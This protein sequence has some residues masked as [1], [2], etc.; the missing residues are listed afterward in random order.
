MR[1]CCSAP[2]RPAPT[3]GPLPAPT[4]RRP[5]AR[6][7]LW[8][9]VTATSP[10]RVPIRAK[11]VAQA[12]AKAVPRAQAQAQVMAKA[13]AQV[14]VQVPVQVLV[15]VPETDP[16]PPKQEQTAGEIQRDYVFLPDRQTL[17]QEL[18]ELCIAAYVYRLLLNCAKGVHGAT[19][20]AMRTAADN[21]S[22]MYEELSQRL[23]R[24][25]QM[26]ATT[27][28]IELSGAAAAEQESGA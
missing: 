19:L 27:E 21:S 12:A 6:S 4:T 2:T 17:R 24:L 13:T 9:L 7:P 8:S 15:Q 10:A 20:A 22:E 18:T 11:A 25:R 26:S 5:S 1:S 3:L 16:F 14:Q 23:N 28:V